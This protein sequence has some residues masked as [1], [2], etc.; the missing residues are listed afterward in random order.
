MTVPSYGSQWTPVTPES[1]QAYC[2][3]F[4]G[5]LETLFIIET[6]HYT[7]AKVLNSNVI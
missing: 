3:V 4:P 6:R 1:S 5:A 2:P 7:T